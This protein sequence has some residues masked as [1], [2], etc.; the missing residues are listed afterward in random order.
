MHI[1]ITSRCG[2]NPERQNQEKN[3]SKRCATARIS[4][5]IH[6]NRCG[7]S[8]LRLRATFGSFAGAVNFLLI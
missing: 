5:Q 2:L 1:E 4:R 3:R 8:A 7:G 6:N